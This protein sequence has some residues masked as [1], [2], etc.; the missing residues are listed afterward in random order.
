MTFVERLRYILEVVRPHAPVV[1]NILQIL[2]RLVRHSVQTAYQV[3]FA[4]PLHTDSENRLKV[5]YGNEYL[6][7]FLIQVTQCPRLLDTVFNEFLPTTWEP[8]GN[9]HGLFSSRNVTDYIR[10]SILCDGIPCV[11]CLFVRY[12]SNACTC[13]LFQSLDNP[14]L[15][16]TVYRVLIVSSSSD[17]CAQ[18]VAT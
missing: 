1:I 7:F 13:F 15:T 11:S 8:I 16:C 17:Y 10:S 18:L 9:R 12:V 5:I 14:Y 6:V 4:L 3:I 2:S